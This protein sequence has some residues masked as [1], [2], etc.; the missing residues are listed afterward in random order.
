MKIDV[1]RVGGVRGTRIYVASAR[2]RSAPV[3]AARTSA[4]SSCH[5]FVV[6]MPPRDI[7]QDPPRAKV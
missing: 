4:L 3:G 6:Q 7:P 5:F 2:R 1:A